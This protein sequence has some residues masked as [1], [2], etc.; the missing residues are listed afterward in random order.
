LDLEAKILDIVKGIDGRVGLAIKHLD[1]GES[2]LYNEHESFPTASV[3]KVPVLIELFN[4]VKQRKTR[5][6]KILT[7]RDQDK[8]PGSGVLKELRTGLRMTIK[9][10]ATLMTIVSDNTATDMIVDH[11]GLTKINDTIHR[12]G[13]PKTQVVMHCKDILFN[14]VDIDYRK[15]SRRQLQKGWQLLKEGKINPAAR[16]LS[17]K[18]NNTSTAKEM[19]YIFEELDKHRILDGRS[20]EGILDMLKRQ[21][22][23]TR[24]PLYLPVTITVAHKTGSLRGIRNDSGII[25][26][27]KT[28]IAMSIFTREVKNEPDADRSIGLIAKAAYD[29]FSA[30]EA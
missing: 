7:V 29:H 9:D 14:L 23:N 11:L 17:T 21:Q 28:R 10:L 5:L 30:K 1:S 2:I 13:Y 25:Y 19:A 24:I 15:A 18:G 4:R 8:S 3:F 27:P 6:D 22:L 12:L 26:L 20:C 16:A